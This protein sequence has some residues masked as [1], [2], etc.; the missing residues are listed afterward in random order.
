M[1]GIGETFPISEKGE[2]WFV[3]IW[4]EISISS[5]EIKFGLKR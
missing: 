3:K 4:K 2:S 5:D 1:I